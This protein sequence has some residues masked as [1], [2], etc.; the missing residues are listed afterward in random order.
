MLQAKSLSVPLKYNSYY[1]NIFIKIQVR[2][3]QKFI[4]VT[5]EKMGGAHESFFF[6][7]TRTPTKNFI[8]SFILVWETCFHVTVE[9]DT[10]PKVKGELQSA[11]ENSAYFKS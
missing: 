7:V 8:I 9:I 5:L 11:I 10:K 1:V 3:C 2:L 4:T 6:Q